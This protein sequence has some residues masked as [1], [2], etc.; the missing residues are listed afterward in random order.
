M[1][2][3]VRGFIHAVYYKFPRYYPIN[4]KYDAVGMGSFG[5]PSTGPASARIPALDKITKR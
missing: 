4:S 5:L 3:H 1:D 2:E